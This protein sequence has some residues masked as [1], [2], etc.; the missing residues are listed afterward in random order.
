VT[1][2]LGEF[3]GLVLAGSPAEFKTFIA[4]DTVKWGEV[5]KFAGLKPE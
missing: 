5:V 2:R 1:S 4:K 3:G